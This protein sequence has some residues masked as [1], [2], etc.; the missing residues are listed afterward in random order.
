VF[1]RTSGADG[2]DDAAATIATAASAP[3]TTVVA[4][5]RRW[6]SRGGRV[7]ADTNEAD[8]RAVGVLGERRVLRARSGVRVADGG[9]T[10]V[11]TVDDS[12]TAGQ[13]VHVHRRHGALR[14]R[15][16][17]VLSARIRRPAGPGNRRLRA[18]DGRPAPAPG[19]R[20]DVLHAPAT[21]R[22][23]PRPSRSGAAP[24]PSVLARRPVPLMHMILQRCCRNDVHEPVDLCAGPRTYVYMC[25]ILLYYNCFV[26]VCC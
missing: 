26:V 11:G 25:Y 19:H 23:P 12:G 22:R 1:G 15:D 13:R 10:V 9:R 20:Q 7:Q 5:K 8:V 18:A 2:R 16:R 4:G 6:Y 21:V 17:R 14:P 24:F 3:A